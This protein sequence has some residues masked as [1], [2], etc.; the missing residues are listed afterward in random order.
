MIPRII[1]FCWYGG[2]AYSETI[3]KCIKSWETLLP[4]YEIIRWD[5]SNTPFDSMPFLKVLYKQKRW[6]FIADYMRLY[7]I[8]KHGGIYFDTDVE[9]IRTFDGLLGEKAFIGFQ[10]EI[11]VSKFPFNTAVIGCE[12]GNGF[13]EL[14]LQETEKLQRM[15]YHPMAAPVVSTEVL[16]NKYGVDTYKTQRLKDVLLLEKDYFYPFSWTETFDESCITPNTLAIHWWEDSWGN[17]KKN[18]AY[19]WRSLS[20]KIERTPLILASRL[21]YAFGNRKSFFL[22]PLHHHLRRH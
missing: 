10:T 9:V 13:I 21:A 19:Y 5:E 14:C 4:D 8:F 12:K 7:A 15:K 2:G 1:H 11:G 22:Y 20:R 3:Q 18:I 17:K 16:M 6:A